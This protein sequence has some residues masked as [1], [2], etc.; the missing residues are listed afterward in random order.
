MFES[1]DE[2]TQART[3]AQGPSYKLTERL[4]QSIFFRCSR[5]R[6]ANTVVSEGI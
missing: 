1:V 3:P 6:A 4:R 2:G 5:P